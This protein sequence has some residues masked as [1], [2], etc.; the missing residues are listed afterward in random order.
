MV[1][2]GAP[3]EPRLTGDGSPYLGRIERL[4]IA[5]KSRV[6]EANAARVDSSAVTYPSRTSR[7]SNS[8]IEWLRK[9][10]NRTKFPNLTDQTNGTNRPSSSP[11][12]PMNCPSLRSLKSSMN[13]MS[14]KTSSG[15]CYHPTLFAPDSW[16]AADAHEVS[17]ASCWRTPEARCPSRSAMLFRT[18]RS[19]RRERPPSFRDMHGRNQPP[20]FCQASSPPVGRSRRGPLHPGLCGPRFR[21]AR[22]SRSCV[23]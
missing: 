13:P 7:K 17:A 19:R 20:T 1:G 14:L 4:A 21:S 8:T 12:S 23:R 22:W 2:Q 16:R 3:A 5:K 9:N 6:R 15:A 10:R 11:R 18:G